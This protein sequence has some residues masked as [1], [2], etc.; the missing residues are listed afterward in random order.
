M[1]LDELKGQE[2]GTTRV[3]IEQGPVRT[4][5][6]AVKDDPAAFT[7]D[8][9]LV[10]PTF[11]F[12]MPYWGSMGEGGAAG[13]PIDKLRGKGKMLLHGEQEFE[14]HDW[15]TVGDELEGTARV[16]DVRTK[17]SEKATMDFYVTETEWR[18]ADSGD[19]AATA[20]FTLIVRTAKG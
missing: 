13:L 17:D 20:R 18:H 6:T 14:Y 5:A 9:A 7:G 3:K 2:L 8:G 19:L 1:A 15:P 11:P 16:A 12:V 4:F 10:P